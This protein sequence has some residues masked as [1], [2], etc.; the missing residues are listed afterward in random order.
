M[1]HQ[2]YCLVVNMGD[3]ITNFVDVKQ[4]K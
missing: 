3:F 2:Q 1:A 4:Q